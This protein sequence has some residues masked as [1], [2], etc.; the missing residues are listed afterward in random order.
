MAHLCEHT[1]DYA[2]LKRCG[3]PASH[4]IPVDESTGE[5]AWY[6]DDHWVEPE[7]DKSKAEETT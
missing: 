7:K 3:R 6:C 1:I 4:S 5:R 2:T